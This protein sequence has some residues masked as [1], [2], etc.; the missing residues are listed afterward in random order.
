MPDYQKIQDEKR[1]RFTNCFDCGQDEYDSCSFE[2]KVSVEPGDLQVD[3]DKTEMIWLCDRCRDTL[4]EFVSDNWKPAPRSWF[5][6]PRSK[7]ASGDI[8]VF[9]T[10]D[11]LEEWCRD[12]EDMINDMCYVFGISN[13]RQLTSSECQKWLRSNK[14]PK[15]VTIYWYNQDENYYDEEDSKSDWEEL[16]D[17]YKCGDNEFSSYESEGAVLK[18]DWKNYLEAIKKRAD[19]AQKRIDKVRTDVSRIE[20]LVFGG[21]RGVKEVGE[22]KKSEEQL[23][24]EQQAKEW[25]QITDNKD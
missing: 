23:N 17:L 12:E 25:A 10:P 4:M 7:K 8:H 3:D 16:F 20:K 22:V 2:Y 6:R 14:L 24:I 9:Y 21:E 19:E 13:E 5:A 1:A 15:N 18:I 11:E